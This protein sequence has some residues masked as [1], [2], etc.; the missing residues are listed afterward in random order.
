MNKDTIKS[1]YFLVFFGIT[2]YFCVNNL[3][4][5]FKS[6]SFVFSVLKPLIYGGILAFVLIIP[7]SFFEKLFLK[8]FKK[9]NRFLA[10]SLVIILFIIFFNLLILIVVPQAINSLSQ[11]AKSLEEIYADL[12]LIIN[13]LNEII[14]MLTNFFNLDVTSIL[15]EVTQMVQTF[16]LSLISGMTAFVSSI[17]TSVVNAVV[18]FIFSAYL[19]FSKEKVYNIIKDFIYIVLKK[20]KADSVYKVATLTNKSFQD[21]IIGQVSEAVILGGIF[22]VVLTVLNFEYAMLISTILSVTS[23]VPIFG[24]I[25]GCVI[26]VFF[27]ATVN[28]YQAIAFIV[29]FTIIQQIE[30]NLIYPYVVGSR[31]GIPPILVF[32]SVVLGAGFGGVVGMITF[33]PLCAVF[34]SLLKE[35][36]KN[37]K[38]ELVL[39]NEQDKEKEDIE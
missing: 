9:S 3:E 24:A 17:V 11:I 2:F 33:V 16:T 29:I 28:I 4:L 22:V 12:P 35:F 23:L 8:H 27:L 19:I 10:W 18:A 36:I 5:V 14:P 15:S 7:M 25:V 26:G 34:Y 31:I 37:N 32:L 21:F 1:L 13:E 30:G 6:V 38:K 39:E 20:E